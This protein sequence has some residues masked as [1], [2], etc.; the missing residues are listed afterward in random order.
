MCAPIS[1]TTHNTTILCACAASA[2]EG[3]HR[4]KDIQ[5]CRPEFSP[6]SRL[7]I[8]ALD[9]ALCRICKHA[10]S[11]RLESL[12]GQPNITAIN[13][14]KYASTLHTKCSRGKDDVFEAICSNSCESWLKLPALKKK[15]PAL[16]VSTP[17]TDV[18]V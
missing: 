2:L 1:I 18:E 17:A 9:I 4:C 5:A 12:R 13:M 15:N 10:D 6:M 3:Q 8:A 11:A 16:K 14:Y 7:S